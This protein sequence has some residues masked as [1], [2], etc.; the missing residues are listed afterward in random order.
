MN[1]DSPEK[2][3]NTE[4][5]VPPVEG[6][7]A[8]AETAEPAAEKPVAEA[9][10]EKTAVA[11]SPSEKELE[12]EL[13]KLL[14]EGALVPPKN[15][16]VS[17]LYE[18]FRGKAGDKPPDFLA[19]PEK[20]EEK[21]LE[22]IWTK[23]TITAFEEMIKHDVP[24][25]PGKFHEYYP[26][27]PLYILKE[28]AAWLKGVTNILHPV[29]FLSGIGR[30]G[31][32]E[33]RGKEVTLPKSSFH[34]PYDFGLD[35]DR[36]S[37]LLLNGANIGLKHGRLI[38]YN[39]VRCALADARR[40][41]DKA[42]VLTN[43]LDLEFIEGASPLQVYRAVM[44]GLKPKVA[45]FDKSYRR[46]ARRI[47]EK[48]PYDEMV[49]TTA[50]EEFAGVL[51][52]W[53]K[54]CFQPSGD[55][56]FPGPIFIILGAKE[57]RLIARAAAWEY[58]YFT[59]LKQ[60]QLEAEIKA[61]KS[62]L[63]HA[64]R[65]EDEVEIRR[66]KKQLAVLTRQLSRTRVSNVA[67][68]ERLR[69]RS[70]VRS[71]VI[72]KIEEAIPNSK[73]ISTGRAT[74][75]KFGGKTAL[76]F[77][78]PR[79]N[80]TDTI[81]S[82]WAKHY[83]PQVLKEGGLPDIVFICHPHSINRR[84]TRRDY[85]DVGGRKS[86]QIEV[87]PICVDDEFLR[88]TL[89]DSTSNPH[90]IAQA[91][92][93]WDFRPGVIRI[94]C[95]NNILSVDDVSVESLVN[96]EKKVA[97]SKN[98]PLPDSQ[99]PK[100]R[101]KYIW[102]YHPSD[103]HFGSLGNKEAIYNHENGRNLGVCEAVIELFRRAGL[104]EGAKLPIHLVAAEDDLTQGNHFQIQ[105]Q[106]NPRT[107]PY[108]MIQK[109]WAEL[110]AAMKEAGGARR[111]EIFEEAR[112]LNLTQFLL[113]GEPWTQDQLEAFFEMAL[114]PNVDFYSAVLQRAAASGIILKG[115]S[116][117]SGDSHPYDRRD[118]GLISFPTGNHFSNTV[119][120]ELAEGPIAARALRGL[121]SGLPEWSGNDKKELLGK[122]IKGPLY[123]PEFLAWGTIKAPGGYEWGL[124]F[125]GEP[126]RLSSWGD[127]LMG[128]VRN[129]ETR[130]P[131]H[132]MFNGR[133]ALKVCGD[134]HFFGAVSTSHSLYRMAGPGTHTDLYGQKGFPPNNTGVLF[135]GLPVDGPDGG[136][137]LD[138]I[139]SYDFLR[140]YFRKP[141]DFDWAE[142]LPNPA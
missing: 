126:T 6:Q 2:S 62:A 19:S 131:E 50:A 88:E 32:K 31:G 69:Y 74:H 59:I 127:T 5:K 12:N 33:M 85:S 68:K 17:D 16:S 93:R 116:E 10:S 65:D 73:V 94:S 128:W 70:Y 141:F 136:P 75:I 108:A 36:W 109:I 110:S 54:I 64:R 124:E 119:N 106:P 27:I 26:Y 3:D 28:K 23:R 101:T 118:V 97:I 52:G 67:A 132:G 135:V 137:I 120:R 134:K 45:L 7:G 98:K 142:F 112:Q 125:R 82:N 71:L 47:L 13:E 38:Q 18:F 58:R 55:P 123:P 78:P 130:A 21:V 122:W 11:A 121:L 35:G 34:N 139:I 51:S 22:L 42:V 56:E 91:V 66:L 14:R 111:L 48:E 81:L 43:I 79:T 80:V 115:V 39:P 57:E 133:V 72:R 44:S 87:L 138:R 25:T 117:F 92:N 95:A 1:S 53:S 107:M 104:C 89:E 40:R 76:F 105:Q 49:Y 20:F 83:A 77:V 140:D 30:L 60:Y 129:D 37:A 4:A 113:R 114:E 61:V 8:V 99:Y 100:W 29:A 41:G 96:V 86:A 90:P 9:A 84:M 103:P 63:A 102:T 15:K 46:E 24:D